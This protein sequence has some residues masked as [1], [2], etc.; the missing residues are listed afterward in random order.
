MC[1]DHNEPMNMIVREF[2]RF[3][4]MNE[5]RGFVHEKKLTALS[6][7]NNLVHFPQH[8]HNKQVVEEAVRETMEEV[9]GA[10]EDTLES[11]IVDL[12]LD[13]AGRVWVVEVN[14]FGEMAGSCL[15][16]WSLDREVLM[17]RKPFQFRIVEEEQT[18]GRLKAEL[19]KRVADIL[20]I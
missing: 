15:F 11:F 4:V 9:I 7:Y 20:G 16:S 1:L 5:L 8:R 6:Q 19:D 13:E 17:G 2:V 3:P 12:V 14:P 18:V 10:M